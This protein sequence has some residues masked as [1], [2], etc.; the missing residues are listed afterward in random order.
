MLKPA[1]ISAQIAEIEQGCLSVD[2][3]ERWFRLASRNFHSDQ[4]EDAKS[5]IF[6]IEN[7]LSEYHADLDEL[8]AQRDLAEAIR[9]FEEQREENIG[10][11]HPADVFVPMCFSASGNNNIGSNTISSI[12]A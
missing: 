12:A 2:D 7:V 5:A 11:N 1:R 3:F 8:A 10:S 9:P 6:E 4:D